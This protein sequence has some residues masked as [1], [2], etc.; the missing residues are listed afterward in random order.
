M[1]Q[2][3]QFLSD[4]GWFIGVPLLFIIVVIYVFRPSAE[5]MYQEEGKIPLEDENHKHD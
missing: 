1:Q 2:V 5:K 3:L 4:Y